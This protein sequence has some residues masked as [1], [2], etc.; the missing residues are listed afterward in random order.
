MGKTYKGTRGPL[1][2]NFGSDANQATSGNSNYNA[3]QITLRHSSKRLSV[4][5]GY[6]YSKSE[7]Q[8]SNI[9]E[10]VNPLDPSLSKALSAFDV[11]HNFVVSYSYTIPFEILSRNSNRWTEGW[12]ISGIS[13]FTRACP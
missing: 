3:L 7:D 11:K 8:S 5:A 10:E 13:H 9:G 4:L 2:S 6:T 1:G 12:E